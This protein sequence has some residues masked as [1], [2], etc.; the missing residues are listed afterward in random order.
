MFGDAIVTNTYLK[1]AIF[2]L[3]VVILALGITQLKTLKT[4]REFQPLIIRIDQ[5]GRAETV[6]YDDLTY[7]PQEAELKY[8]LSDFTRLY[9]SRNRATLAGN[10]AKFLTFLAPDLGEQIIAAWTKHRLIEDYGRSGTHTIDID[11]KAVAIEDLKARPVRA[12]VDFEQI[13]YLP[14]ERTETK[15]V[16]YTA[17]FAFDYAKGAIP[18][19]VAQVNPLGIMIVQFREDEASN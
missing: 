11:I 7:T 8:F 9:Y 6:R 2:A 13:Y 4:L 1:I 12:R 19:R 18:P 17:S 10:Y 5:I 3:S 15:R 16:L 14:M